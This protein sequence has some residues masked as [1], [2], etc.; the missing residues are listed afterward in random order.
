MGVEASAMT[1]ERAS[2]MTGER[3]SVMIGEKASA[4]IELRDHPPDPGEAIAVLL[5]FIDVLLGQGILLGR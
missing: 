4:M 2:S 3:A 1:R 5:Q